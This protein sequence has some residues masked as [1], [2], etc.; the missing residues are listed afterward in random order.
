MRLPARQAYREG[1]PSDAPLS[2]ASSTR[3]RCLRRFTAKEHEPGRPRR[4][5]PSSATGHG[6]STILCLGGGERDREADD[7]Q[8]TVDERRSDHPLRSADRADHSAHNH[9]AGLAVFHL[10]PVTPAGPVAAGGGLDDQALDAGRPVVRA[11]RRRLVTIRRAGANLQWRR[12]ASREAFEASTAGRVG[13]A[14]LIL[15]IQ[16]EH[17]EGDVA[18]RRSLGP[19]RAARRA[20][21]CCR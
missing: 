16:C 13:Q 14:A 8:L 3:A 19:A 12:P 4:S 21:R 17:V 15:A 11:P 6:A 5:K 2:S 1:F 10:D 7:G 20:R 9:L 18:G